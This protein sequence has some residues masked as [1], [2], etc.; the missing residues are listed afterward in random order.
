MSIAGNAGK[1]GGLGARDKDERERER[2][3]QGRERESYKENIKQNKIEEC[4]L[5]YI[6]SIERTL[7]KKM[8]SMLYLVG[9]VL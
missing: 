6:R 4:H 1:R 8:I 9:Y 2:E 5:W 3:L 7:N